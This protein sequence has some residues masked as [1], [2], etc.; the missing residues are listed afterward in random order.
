VFPPHQTQWLYNRD[1]VHWIRLLWFLHIRRNG[2]NTVTWL[3][4]ARLALPKY[5]GVRTWQILAFHLWVQFVTGVQG[6]GGQK[7]RTVA[8]RYRLILFADFPRARSI[9]HPKPRRHAIPFPAPQPYLP[10][11]VSTRCDYWTNLLVH[12]KTEPEL[13]GVGFCLFLR[14][15]EVLAYSLF[16]SSD[17]ISPNM[18]HSKIKYWATV[19][20]LK[21]HNNCT[22]QFLKTVNCSC[23]K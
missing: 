14:I 20:N 12:L 15:R 10:V 7:E 4:E 9:W 19:L 6:G 3:L 23:T 11:L 8:R 2:Y 13:A 1:S 22:E 16:S 17:P 5:K 18:M 21:L